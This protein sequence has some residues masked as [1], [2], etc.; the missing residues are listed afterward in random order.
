MRLFL[1]GLGLAALLLFGLIL[2]ALLQLA[3]RLGGRKRVRPER[4]TRFWHRL[5]LRLLG[6]H[7]TVH[8]TAAP[9]AHLLVANHVSWLDIPLIAGHAPVR[10]VSKIEVRRMPVA[11]WL[12]SGVNTFYIDRGRG[13]LGP[14]MRT[15]A[16]SLRQ[17]RSVALFPEGT[18]HDGAA[19]HAFHSRL[20]AVAFDGHRPV[21]PVALRYGPGDAGRPVAPFLDQGALTHLLGLL[22]NRRLDAE[23]YFLPPIP[24]EGRERKAVSEQA[25]AAIAAALQQPAQAPGYTC[26]SAEPAEPS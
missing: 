9:G 1:R 14:L 26:A 25:R 2:V 3:L 16:A 15:L 17:G 4:L 23:L 18:T 6:L 11:G 21:Q 10:F 19:V 24:I 8:G 7:L 12:A 20:F 5:L 22:R 13:A